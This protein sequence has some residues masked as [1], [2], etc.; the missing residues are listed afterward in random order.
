MLKIPMFIEL[1]VAIPAFLAR[2]LF[3]TACAGNPRLT[4]L[5]SAYVFFE[6]ATRLAGQAYPAR[7]R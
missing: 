5:A 3:S 2:W 1:P 7:D 6:L 4:P